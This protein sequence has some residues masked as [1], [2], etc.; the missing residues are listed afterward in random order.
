MSN[1]IYH[2]KWHGFNHHT[3][4]TAGFP[5][6][7][8]DPIASYDYPFKSIFY[9]F[10]QGS[11]L[12][13]KNITI[14]STG[15]G[16]TT[17][18]KLQ[19]SSRSIT[20][21]VYK[22]GTFKANLNTKSK[23]ITSVD[24]LDGGNY[25]GSVFM[26]I[27]PDAGDFIYK[28]A[29]LF[30]SAGI[31]TIG[32]DSLGWATCSSL[33]ETYSGDWNRW[34]SVETNV[35]TY[36]GFWQ[37]GFQG[38]TTLKANS[39][40]YNDV[41]T[42]TKNVSSELAYD[43]GGGTGW[44][45]ALSSTTHKL[46]TSAINIR[47]KAAV[48]VQL[49]ENSNRTITWITTA[50]TVYFNVTGNYTL[51]ANDVFE[52]KKGGKYTM[53]LAVDKCPESNSNIIFNPSKYIIS[54]KDA[55]TVKQTNTNV[56]VLSARHITR[57][58][59][60]YDGVKMLGR[61]T[62]YFIDLP[63][64][65]DTYY[66]GTGITFYDSSFRKRN[67][68][69]VNNIPFDIVEPSFY[70]TKGIGTLI[71]KRFF[72]VTPVTSSLYIAGTGIKMRFLG[73]SQQYFSFNLYGAEWPSE[74]YLTKYPAVTSSFDRVVGLSGGSWLNP[75]YGSNLIVTPV[76]GDVP[77]SIIPK[78][79]SPQYTLGNSNLIALRQC[80]SS[81][82]IEIYSGKDRYIDNLVLNGA[83]IRKVPIKYN[84]Q[85]QPFNF[86]NEET[87]SLEFT[88]IQEDQ[89]IEVYYNQ[90]PHITVGNIILWFNSMDDTLF[91]P[92]TVAVDEWRS[93]TSSTS[94]KLVQTNASFR[95]AL[96]TSG[97]LR[98]VY[99]KNN[100]YLTLNTPL[101]SLSSTNDKLFSVPFSTVSVL[102]FDSLP[103]G[104]TY[105]WWLGPS[106]NRGYGLIARGN[107]LYTR[108][109]TRPGELV[110][111]A[112]LEVGK[113]YVIT[114]VYDGSKER[115]LVDNRSALKTTKRGV[116]YREDQ[117]SELSDFNFIVGKNPDSSNGYTDLK[118]YEFLM[119]KKA[120]TIPEINRVN[121][122]L[123][124]KINGYKYTI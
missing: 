81:Y 70:M 16:Y 40:Y 59:F 96:T 107:K 41:Y 49:T 37:L 43:G 5:D 106:S 44:H 109:G 86:L 103:T 15:S 117:N 6:S 75:V 99:L 9:N 121:L 123:I 67:P 8:T 94:Y 87:A 14:T 2:N 108:V 26:A 79:P 1:Q 116:L 63:T 120:L 80:L 84:N 102:E 97:S 77:P 4:P 89:E 104:P 30:L 105:I 66:K 73:A 61:A 19:L 72:T 101:T 55:T 20:G 92:Y 85:Y 34:R 76:S 42:I 64:K 39:G 82:K 17:T 33:T 50:Q 62:D 88:R 10:I 35:T 23:T 45:I 56:L 124:E 119:F 22:Q 52:A 74:L 110:D 32:S 65:F 71:D 93:N 31:Y 118:L 115:I 12:T 78:F 100:D 7:S 122:F 114:T 47:Q 69:Q 113:K 98:G 3:Q 54:V 25:T 38:Y 51:T 27:I 111:N 91:K 112:T 11:G 68:I 46:N 95:P 24:V 28:Q 58:D 57:I 83:S 13:V 21:K 60:V 36:S 18:P 53:W 48:P 29:V 90:Q